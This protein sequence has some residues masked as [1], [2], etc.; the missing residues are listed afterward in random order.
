MLAYINHTDQKL[1]EAIKQDNETAFAELF[2]RH[3][4][5]A[6][7]IAFSKVGSR[8]TTEDIVQELFI[9]LWDK[10]K[11]LAIKNFPAY[12]YTSIKNSSLNHIESKL[13]HEKY[14]NYYKEFIPKSEKATEN[15]VQYDDLLEAIDQG[16]EKLSNKSKEIFFL[17]HLEGRSIPEIARQLN[18]SEKAIQYHITKSIK[19]LRIYLSDFIIPGSLTII[20]NIYLLRYLLH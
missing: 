9:S 6:Q 1:L 12:I 5:R 10:R 14:W 20:L 7:V 3:W 19:R 17:N 18:L 15:M 13:I 4:K 2:R 16:L 11:S 8:E